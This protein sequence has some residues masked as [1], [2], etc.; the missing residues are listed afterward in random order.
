MQV[1][2]IIYH[3]KIKY[4]NDIVDFNSEKIYEYYNGIDP[5]CEENLKHNFYPKIVI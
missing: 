3:F 2:F 4:I 1:T 5:M